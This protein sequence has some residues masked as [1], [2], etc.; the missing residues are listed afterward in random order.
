MPLPGLT[1]RASGKLG[2]NSND[3]VGLWLLFILATLLF[4]VPFSAAQSW[5]QVWSDEFNGPAG[6]A[7]DPSNWTYDTGGGGWGN[8]ELEIYCAPGSN[9]SP[10]SASNP[11]IYQDGN[12]NLVIKA[13]NQSGTWTSGRMKTQGLHEFQYGRIEA[14]MKLPVGAGLWPAF[15]MLGTNIGSV[16][17]PTCG[18]Q[19]IMEWV[20]QYTPTT[21]SSTIHGPGYSGGS[22]IGRPFTFT[23]GGIADDPGCHTYGVIWSQDQMQFY[24]D[25]Y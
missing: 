3:R 13:I 12:G 15:W 25:D 4:L 20:P 19:D 7:P 22:G 14:R 23:S 16:G 10:C 9:A 6:S 1:E 5:T 2:G 17:W 21:T 24:R 11:N 18:E 8:N